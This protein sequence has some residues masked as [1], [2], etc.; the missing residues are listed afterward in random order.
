MWELEVII[1]RAIVK[2][3][4]NLVNIRVA[5]PTEIF[6]KYHKT[7]GVRQSG[8]SLGSQLLPARE[9]LGGRGCPVK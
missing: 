4:Q 1:I 8:E 5:Y 7:L 2:L 9:S 3:G 6:L